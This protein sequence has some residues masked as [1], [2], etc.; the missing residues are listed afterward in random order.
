MVQQSHSPVT[1]KTRT[2]H[3]PTE[4]FLGN[5]DQERIL[6][7]R[8]AVNSWEE[9]HFLMNN[10]NTFEALSLAS[11]C[12]QHFVVQNTSMTLLFLPTAPFEDRVLLYSPGCIIQTNND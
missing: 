9:N 7:D 1:L 10:G 3:P 2:S 5:S 11:I 8:A 4:H 12:S 6:D